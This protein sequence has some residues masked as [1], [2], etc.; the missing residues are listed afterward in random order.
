MG[1]AITPDKTDSLCRV[2]TYVPINAISHRQLRNLFSRSTSRRTIISEL[3]QK[4]NSGTLTFEDQIELQSAI[5]SSNVVN[6]V[7][8]LN[9]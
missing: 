3:S 6:T 4:L 7:G 2:A 1:T 5:A 9:D 8:C